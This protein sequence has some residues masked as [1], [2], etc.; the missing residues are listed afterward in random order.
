MGSFWKDVGHAIINPIDKV[1]SEV[2]GGAEDGFN[3]LTG[4]GQ[5]E[6]AAAAARE[7]RELQLLMHRENIDLQKEFAQM[8]IRWRVDDAKA[9]GIHPLAA[10]GASGASYSPSIPIID[11]L[12]SEKSWQHNLGQNLRGYFMNRLDPTS[13][14]LGNLSVE[15]ATL[16]NDLLKLE[17][18]NKA[19]GQSGSVDPYLSGQPNSVKGNPGVIDEPLR[20]TASDPIDP[21]KE[22]GAYQDWQMVRTEKGYAVVPAKGV[23]QAI[24]DSPMEYQWLARAALRNYT[25]PDGT[26]AKM[27]PITGELKPI[28]KS[29]GFWKD[30]WSEFKQGPLGIWR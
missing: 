25:L 16:E 11:P 21:S 10:V 4:R 8:G 9:A 1:L 6:D 15:R 3:F 17:L 29:Q 23:K 22:V 7:A 12:P 5:S 18:Q 24:E 19:L 2:G 20:R 26:P 28:Q 13:R 27:N 14:M 30:V